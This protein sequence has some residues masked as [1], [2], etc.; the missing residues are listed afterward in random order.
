MNKSTETTL[1]SQ[2]TAGITGLPSTAVTKEEV[3]QRQAQTIINSMGI[4]TYEDN[5]SINIRNTI[6]SG[7]ARGENVLI[8]S[9]SQ[10]TLYANIVYDKLMKDNK[11]TTDK[12]KLLSVADVASA[13]PNGDWLSSVVDPI[14]ALVKASL[15]AM[16]YNAYE[17][18]N[19]G[20]SLIDTYLNYGSD[21]LALFT[22]KA[23][24]LLD[25][26]TS[27][28]FDG[29]IKVTFYGMANDPLF[30]MLNLPW[31]VGADKM[32]IW[33]KYYYSSET[34]G[35]DV[36]YTQPLPI[37]NEINGTYIADWTFND[38]NVTVAKIECGNSTK[39]VPLTKSSINH[40]G[41][42]N[43][44]KIDGGYTCQIQ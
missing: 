14:I 33:V 5:D 10:G 25:S 22:Q 16:P 12:I 6:E 44:I 3:E 7:I 21:L 13:M 43:I 24:D 1:I 2:I 30:T 38:V 11:I 41:I 4:T 28:L 9:H 35:N 29:E 27:T 15:S 23:H 40:F 18:T 36:I 19:V 32:P 17:C 31:I 20:H 37:T 42:I 34:L 8:V 39:T 26:F